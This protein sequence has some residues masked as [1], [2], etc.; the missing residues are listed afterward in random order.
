MGIVFSEANEKL[1]DN[2]EDEEMVFIASL[3]SRKFFDSFL[4]GFE[5]AI[6]RMHLEG[7]IKK[8]LNIC[9][10]GIGPPAWEASNPMVSLLIDDV[11]YV[12][13]D[14][15]NGVLSLGEIWS[16]YTLFM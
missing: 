14:I 8:Q 12:F 10:R 9:L 15:E 16:G 13:A 3:V 11:A 2:G 6:P 4:R 7:S 5:I 1:D